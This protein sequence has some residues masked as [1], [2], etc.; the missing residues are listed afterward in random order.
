MGFT[1]SATVVL[2]VIIGIRL[3]RTTHSRSR[4]DEKM[5]ALSCIT[6]GVLIAATPLGQGI[7]N[8]VAS[9]AQATH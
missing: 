1:V 6:F 2:G 8:L 4:V 7:F 3:M 5:T 9:A